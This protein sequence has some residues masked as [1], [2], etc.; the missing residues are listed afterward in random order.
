[1]ERIS[2]FDIYKIGV[3]PSS[4]H[5][6][7]P[8]RSALL[9]RNK[10]KKAKVLSISVKLFGS[11]SKTGIGHGTDIAVQLGLQGYDPIKISIEKIPEII[12]KI[13]KTK[14][15]QF[16]D[17]KIA[18]TQRKTLCSTIIPCRITLML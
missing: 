1:M 16:Y 8:W 6:L 15:I 9:V 12:A 3:G 11:L 2:I 10:Y 17:K 7:G 18:L 14:Q 5:T 4:S 13:K